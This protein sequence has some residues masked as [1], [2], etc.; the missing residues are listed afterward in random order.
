VIRR[1]A[2]AAL[3]VVLLAAVLTAGYL[4]LRRHRVPEIRGSTTVE[5]VPAPPPRPPPEPGLAW[6][7]Y[8][9]NAQRLRAAPIFRHRPP[10]RRLWTFHGQALLEF[11]PVVGYGRVYITTFT[12]RLVALD[13]ETGK[14]LWRYVSGRCGWA[15]PALADHLV[16]ETFIGNADCKSPTRDG[17]IAA[18]DARTGRPRWLRH[19]GPTESS[20]LVA[21]GLV[22]VGDWDGRVW[23]LD[24]HSGRMRWTARLDGA[25]KGSLALDR[26]HLFVGTYG[27]EVA[28]LDARDGR[29]RW[30]SDG[31]GRIYSSPAVA[32]ERV[33]VGSVDGG[34]FAFGE[35]TGD[36]LWSHP[37]GSYVYASPAVWRRLVLVGS[38]DHHF[39]AF[40]AGTGDVRWRFDAD[41]P[42]SGSASVVDGLVY[43]SSFGERTYALEAA[44]GRHVRTWPDG[45]YSPVVVDSRRLYLVGLGR[46]YALVPLKS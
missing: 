20:P 29:V 28:A 37:T 38:Y 22:Y 2:Y 14:F 17:V 16:Y 19:I 25:I 4:K 35:R 45:K 18:F 3:A 11:P 12:G 23:A 7:T 40:D 46:L 8:G 34:V 10:F 36:L 30:R 15:S 1:F 6:P 24:A 13:S 42:V 21:R 31:H 32:Y 5:Y 44:T 9:Y 33:Y 39:Y 27:G 43:F 26:G 41:G